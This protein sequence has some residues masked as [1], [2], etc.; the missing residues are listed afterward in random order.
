[1]AVACTVAISCWPRHVRTRSRPE[2]NGAYRKLRLPSRGNGETIV[3]VSDF[4]GFSI[5]NCALASAAA[6]APMLV[7]DRC[8]AGL[9]LQKLETDRARLRALRPQPVSRS[10]FGV[11]G[12]ERLQFCFRPV[13]VHRGRTGQPVQ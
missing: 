9:Q 1:M 2:D 7:L 6:S 12:D 13:V 10:L 8:I 5:S 3:A 11:L 4:A